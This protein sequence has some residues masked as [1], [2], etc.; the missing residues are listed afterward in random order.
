MDFNKGY[1][2]RKKGD[3]VG[4]LSIDGIDISPITAHF[5]KDGRTHWLWVK[6]KR[7]LE[8]DIETDSYHTKNPTPMFECYLKKQNKDNI[9]YQGEFVFFKFKYQMT[10]IWD[11]NEKEK[12]NLIVERLPMQ[13][14]NIINK[15]NQIVNERKH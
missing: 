5:F 12:L 2:E 6:R 8:Y 3:Y 14:Q 7:I 4:A 9:A 11:S 15:I 13:Q 10:A 1:I